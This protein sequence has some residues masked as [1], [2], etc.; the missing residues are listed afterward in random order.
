MKNLKLIFTIKCGKPCP[1]IPRLGETKVTEVL[2]FL[3]WSEQL[4]LS[5]C[6]SFI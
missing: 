3:R 4:S 1:A 2:F 5:S 6:S